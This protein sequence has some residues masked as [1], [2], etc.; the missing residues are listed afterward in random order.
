MV[1]LNTITLLMFVMEMDCVFCETQTEFTHLI[2]IDLR[3]KCVNDLQMNVSAL[4]NS[5]NKLEYTRT[6]NA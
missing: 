5:I 4:A 3:L 2:H 6:Q 1:S